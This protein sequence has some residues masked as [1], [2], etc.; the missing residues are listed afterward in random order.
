MELLELRKLTNVLEHFREGSAENRKLQKER[1]SGNKETYSRKLSTQAKKTK[2]T[3]TKSKP[4]KMH[5]I[6]KAEQKDL[7]RRSR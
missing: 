5:A 6:E 3:P 1:Q 7:W 4:K 2:T